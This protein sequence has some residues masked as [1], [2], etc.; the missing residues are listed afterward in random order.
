MI[1]E[2]PKEIAKATAEVAKFLQ[3]IFGQSAEQVDGI[4]ADQLKF[5]RFKRGMKI[6]E[7]ARLFLAEKGREPRQVPLNVGVPLLT[8]GSL[9]EDEEMSDRWSALLASSADSEGSPVPPSF[10][11]IL[12]ELSGTDAKSLDA[13]GSFLSGAGKKEEEFTRVTVHAPRIKGIARVSDEEYQIGVDNLLRLNLVTPPNSSF[14][15]F[16]K[17][18]DESLPES[19]R[20]PSFLMNT[21]DS[22]GFTAL[23]LRFWLACK[24]N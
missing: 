24:P 16:K 22:I 11:K 13:I 2:T 4:V 23:G 14:P 9:A 21:K 15:S 12:A 7:K 8:E 19:V 18:E 20:S 17:L 3:K 10:P 6:A 5:V 1:D